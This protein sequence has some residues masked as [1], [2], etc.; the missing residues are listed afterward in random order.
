MNLV[1][2]FCWW[3]WRTKNVS[4]KKMVVQM[5]VGGCGSRGVLINEDWYVLVARLAM[6]QEKFFLFL[7][8]TVHIKPA[9]QGPVK[10]NIT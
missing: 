9:C 8:L 6:A 10:M 4:A 5:A 7:C 2:P 1:A 3:S